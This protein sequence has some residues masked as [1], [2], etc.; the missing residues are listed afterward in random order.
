VELIELY[1]AGIYTMERDEFAKWVVEE[2]K[3]REAAQQLAGTNADKID[4]Q[5]L[6]RSAYQKFQY[7]FPI[8]SS[9]EVSALCSC[10][11]HKHPVFASEDGTSKHPLP[12]SPPL[13]FPSGCFLNSPFLQGIQWDL[14]IFEPHSSAPSEELRYTIEGEPDEK[15]DEHF[16]D[17]M[18]QRADKHLQSELC[19]TVFLFGFFICC[20]CQGLSL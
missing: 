7:D 5:R 9:V 20:F 14:H 13:S 15:Q 19:A 2:L 17:G 10:L 4:R 3:S 18:E 1:A 11:R 8:V 16:I 12:A 6:A